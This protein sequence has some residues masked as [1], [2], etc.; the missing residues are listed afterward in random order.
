MSSPVLVSAKTLQR[1]YLWTLLSSAMLLLLGIV[2]S[3]WF[4][5]IAARGA[6]FAGVE[7]RSVEV[8]QS[9]ND[10]VDVAQ[11]HISV[12]RRT[13]E[14]RLQKPELADSSFFGRVATAA[15]GSPADSPWDTLG[16]GLS[17]HVGS[18]H[19]NPQAKL[20]RK[21]F[22]AGVSVASSILAIAPGVH[23]HQ[24]TFQWSYFY[25]AQERWFL[26]FPTMSRK[27]LFAGTATG[28]MAEA[29]KVVFDAGGT[30]PITAAGPKSNPGRYAVWTRPYLDAGGKG[31]MVTLLAPVYQGD[32]YNGVVGTDITLSILSSLL[33][34]NGENSGRLFVVSATGELLG[35]S[36][37]DAGGRASVASI[38]D[39]VPTIPLE[40]VVSGSV[41]KYEGV[42]ATW[43]QLPIIGTT[44]KLLV[45][46]PHASVRQFVLQ[47][48]LPNVTLAIFLMLSVLGLAWI[49]NRRYAQPALQLAEYVDALESEPDKT[50]PSVPPFW[51]HWFEQVAKNSRDRRELLHKTLQ[52]A[53]QLEETVVRRTAALSEANTTLSSTIDT[54]KSTQSQ[55]VRSEKLAGLGSMVAGVSHELNTPLGNALLMASSLSATGKRMSSALQQGMKKSDLEQ[56]IAEVDQGTEVIERN[57]RVA[58]N[59]VQRFKEVA[60]NQTSEKRCALNLHDVVEGVTIVMGPMLRQHSCTVTNQTPQDIALNSY[61]GFISQ[62]LTNLIANACTHAFDNRPG[63]K[64]HVAVHRV[65]GKRIMLIVSDNGV[66]IDPKKLPRIFDPFF[67]TKMGRGGAGLGLHIVLNVVE[68]I[69]G[70]SIEVDSTPDGTRFSVTLPLTAP[71]KA[72]STG[73]LDG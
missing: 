3:G 16:I 24:K 18:V 45:E 9:I 34:K 57:V 55:L 66:G 5:V 28:D 35:D 44:W 19:V 12:M 30:F 6:F 37:G 38:S 72:D 70:G 43:L 64:I 68:E 11:S 65:D 58:S 48:L 53:A 8:Q 54:L 69:L 13:L 40:Q 63:G 60:V 10:K 61:P 46:V 47:T 21:E 73:K 49:Q 56:F 1:R 4:A 71:E 17:P 33:S 50:A 51:S 23:E 22:E 42:D 29:F 7:A 59:L 27:D 62:V 15:P 32:R 26:V 39:V 41:P 14:T 36:M 31:L 2:V 67:T 25:D 20:D 52:N